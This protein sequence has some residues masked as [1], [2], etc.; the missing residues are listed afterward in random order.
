MDSLTQGLRSGHD[1]VPGQIREAVAALISADVPGAEKKEF[2]KA[3]RTKGETAAEIAVFSQALLAHALTPELDPMRLPG[4]TLDVCGTGGDQ[5]GYF[6]VS[7]AVMFV[8]AACGACVMKHGN[9]SV[10]SKT[11]AADVLEELGVRLELT[12]LRL[13]QCLEQNGV[14]FIFAPAWH[15]AFK[16]IGPVRREL[17]AEGI[18]TI[19]NLLGPLLNPARPD[20]QLVGLFSHVLLPKYA[21]VLRILERRRAWAVHGDGTDEL[22]LTGTSEVSAVNGADIS[23]FSIVPE[24]AGL[25]RCEP[26]ALVGGERVENA[27]ILHAIL[28]GTERGPKLDM[29]LLNS[30]AALVVAGLEANLAAGVDHARRAIEN[31]TALRKLNALQSFR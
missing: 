20:H 28:D 17:A 25:S 9:R 11:G 7:T 2:L 5:R 18:P 27:R 14:A 24:D 13:R 21:E 15:P 3:F 8:A 29:V 19:F 4:P 1:L 31:G 23:A 6:N 16:A 26:P 30:A 22:S 10:T 12:P